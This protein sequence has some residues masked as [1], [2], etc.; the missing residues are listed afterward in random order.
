MIY[1]DEISEN[2]HNVEQ[3][4]SIIVNKL[5]LMYINTTLEDEKEKYKIEQQEV[6]INIY[7][8]NKLIIRICNFTI[9]LF[10]EESK[11]LIQSLDA[12]ANT[13]KTNKLI[14]LKQLLNTDIAAGRV[15]QS[16]ISDF[17][18]KFE[19][20]IIDV[21]YNKIPTYIKSSIILNNNKI[22]NNIPDTILSKSIVL[23]NQIEEEIDSDILEKIVLAAQNNPSN[24]SIIPYIKIYNSK[25]NSIIKIKSSIK[26]CTIN[27]IHY[28]TNQKIEF[29]KNTE[30]SSN[31]EG[32]KKI[33]TTQN[34]IK[35]IHNESQK[36]DIINPKNS[37]FP[38]IVVLIILVT[39]TIIGIIEYNNLITIENND[40]NT[41]NEGQKF[42]Q[43]NDNSIP[44]LKIDTANQ[45][46]ESITTN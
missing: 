14:L 22:P 18:D 45:Q 27:F 6:F 44:P 39:I 19:K 20:I 13:E 7:K 9:I 36:I 11:E 15:F 42:T 5:T 25:K 4:Y 2:N 24:N 40:V 43:E 34:N 21:K 30:I 28:Q 37:K 16:T 10:S 41:L 32:D 26:N 23:S 33:L 35:I 8:C 46:T 31:I 29:D 12:F 1:Y 17:A 3:R 38:V